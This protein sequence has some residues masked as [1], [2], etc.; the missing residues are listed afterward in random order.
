MGVLLGWI[1]FALVAGGAAV[2]FRRALAVRLQGSRRGFVA[3]WAGAA[4]LGVLAL[5]QGPGWIG[6]VPAVLATLLGGFLTTLVGI[7]G[8]KTG[9]DRISVGDTLPA[10]DAPD[11]HGAPFRSESMAGRPQL[12][13]FFRGH[14]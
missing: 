8:Q 12:L 9:T 3:L 11:E 1:A 6:G 2:W 5:A 13:K 4:L 14:W 10:F 7:S